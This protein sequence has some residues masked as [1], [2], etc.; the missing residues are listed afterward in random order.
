MPTAKELNGNHSLTNFRSDKIGWLGAIAIPV[1]AVV[2]IGY[3]A[4][5]TSGAAQH[6]ERR[7]D[8][9]RDRDAGHGAIDQRTTEREKPVMNLATWFRNTFLFRR[10]ITNHNYYEARRVVGEFE[11]QADELNQTIRNSPPD[12]FTAIISDLRTKHRLSHY[13]QEQVADIY[14]KSIPK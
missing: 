12:P 8:Q 2:A 6:V 1:L 14:R 13:D 10:P 3:G 7:H 9:N 11:K 5:G 4:Q